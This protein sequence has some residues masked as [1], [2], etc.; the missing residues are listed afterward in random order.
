MIFSHRLNKSAEPADTGAAIRVGEP[1]R[2]D[3]EKDRAGLVLVVFMRVLAALW[4]FQGILQWIAILLPAEPLFNQL[5]VLRGTAVVFFAIFDF[6][7]AVGLWLATPWGG[8]IWLLG[9]IAQ[10]FVAIALPGFFSVL[11]IGADLVLIVIYFVL[12]WRAGQAGAPSGWS[13]RR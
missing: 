13:R 8:V 2:I 7:A 10:I 3:D 6:V 9:A 12:T 4:V 5:S 1:A 11:W